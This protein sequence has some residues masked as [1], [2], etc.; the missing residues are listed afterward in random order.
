[1]INLCHL[2]RY[3][4][5]DFFADKCDKCDGNP[6]LVDNFNPLPVQPLKTV[7]EETNKRRGYNYGKNA[8]K[9]RGYVR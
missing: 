7:V 2:C 3:Q 8:G 5:R 9:R 1:M 6:D 4:G